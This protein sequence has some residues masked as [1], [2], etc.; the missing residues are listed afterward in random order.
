M[1]AAVRTLIAQMRSLS[2]EQLDAAWETRALEGGFVEFRIRPE[3]YLRAKDKCYAAV[4]E[5]RKG[6][7]EKG[8]KVQY[9]SSGWTR[10]SKLP[11]V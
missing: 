5:V 3:I 10:V 8:F 6:L 9:Q 4:G 1:L 7:A 2:Q 11:E